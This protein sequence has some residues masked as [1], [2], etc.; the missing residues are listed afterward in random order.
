MGVSLTIP[1]FQPT[2]LLVLGKG[3]GSRESWD[4]SSTSTST[5]DYTNLGK[6]GIFL[7]LYCPVFKMCQQF[8]E[9]EISGG[10]MRWVASV[11]KKNDALSAKAFFPPLNSKGYQFPSGLQRIGLVRQ[12]TTCFLGVLLPCHVALGESDSVKSTNSPSGKKGSPFHSKGQQI[13]SP[14]LA[15]H[16]S[17]HRQASGRVI[18]SCVFCDQV[19]WEHTWAKGGEWKSSPPPLKPGRWFLPLHRGENEVHQWHPY[20]GNSTR[21]RT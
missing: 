10:W 8:T 3:S 19:E 1:Y 11:L 12:H 14:L 18:Y 4:V 17:P 7:C 9:T 15:Q 2:E 16:T 6:T 13:H 5:T 21:K 20:S